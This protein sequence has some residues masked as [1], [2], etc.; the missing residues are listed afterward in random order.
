MTPFENYK[1]HNDTETI[2]CAICGAIK[3]VYVRSAFDNNVFQNDPNRI[4]Y[5]VCYACRD[6]VYK[7][8]RNLHLDILKFLSVPEII[9]IARSYR[10]VLST[11]QTYNSEK[12][13]Q[14]LKEQ[15][16]KFLERK[17]NE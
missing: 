4:T 17:L 12:F 1:L 13:K 8:K 5:I 10:A 16:K 9:E 11:G 6:I 15:S 14:F 2:P 7:V 3:S